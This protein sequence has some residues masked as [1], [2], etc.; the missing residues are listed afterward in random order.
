MSRL[1]PAGRSLALAAAAAAALA[2]CS[3]FRPPPPEPKPPA[4]M[5]AG[6]D[7]C[8]AGQVDRTTWRVQCAGLVAQVHDPYGERDE[9]LLEAGRRLA[10]LAGG[11]T[12]KAE[13]ARLPLA[14]ATRAV[15]RLALVSRAEKGRIRAAG[16]VTTVPFGEERT[17]LAWCVVAGPSAA[18]CQAVL[19]LVASLPWRAGPAPA[20]TLPPELAGRPLLVPSGCEAVADPLGG[21]VSCSATDGWRWRRVGLRRDVAPSDLEYADSAEEAG[22]QPPPP[23]EPVPEAPADG[24]PC[25]VDGV[26]TRCDVKEAWGGTMVTI[27]TVA[28]VRGQPLELT[29]SFMGSPDEV[30]E[31]CDGLE[32]VR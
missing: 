24:Q 10:G 26:E 8:L 23:T 4:V 14:G 13:A 1:P 31:V 27:S 16:L 29:C 17:R 6:L 19:D 3:L 12:P 32:L 15:T 21:D 2:G 30:P 28:T 25:L 20:G 7:G 5:A 9:A 22:K 11:G 18:R